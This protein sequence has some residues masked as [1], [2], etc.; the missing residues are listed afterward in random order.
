MKRGFTVVEVLV[1]LVVIAIIL[2]LGTVGLRATLVN[3]RD[4]ERR[5]DIDTIARGL[6]AYYDRGNPYVTSPSTKGTYPGSNDMQLILGRSDCNNI[7]AGSRTYAAATCTV[8]A[9]DVGRALPGVT[10]ASVTPPDSSLADGLRTTWWQ[11]DTTL[12]TWANE[13]YYIYRPYVAPDSAD[14]LAYCGFD[15]PRYELWYKEESSGQIIKV[16]SKHQ[17]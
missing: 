6:E 8:D 4:S 11:P 15:C 10:I 2:G 7:Y 5:A 14:P 17:Q 12:T 9:S 13:G 1:T 3:G 16:K